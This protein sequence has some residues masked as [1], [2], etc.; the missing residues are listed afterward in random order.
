LLLNAVNEGKVYYDPGIKLEDASTSKPKTKK[1]S[2]FRVVS[3]DLPALYVT[4][5]IVDVCKE[6]D[7]EFST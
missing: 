7:A 5:R 1:R 3:K 2:Q 6:S 4:S